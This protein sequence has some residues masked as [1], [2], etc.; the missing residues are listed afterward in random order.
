MSSVIERLDRIEDEF[1]ARNEAFNMDPTIEFARLWVKQHRLNS[2][3]RNSRMK[4]AVATNCPDWDIRIKIIGAVSEEVVADHEY[5]GGQAHF[6]MLE[7]LGTYLGMSREE[8]RNEKPLPTTQIAWL[9]WETLT[10]NRHW[11][12]GLLANTVGERANVPGYG[13]G[14]FRELGHSGVRRIT[15]AKNF[16]LKDDQLK[17]FKVHT[18]A[19]VAHSNLGWQNLAKYAEEMKMGDIIVEAARVNLQVWGLYWDGIV[20]AS[21]QLAGA[22]S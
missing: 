13:L 10:K 22:R 21:R 16:G 7:D 6:D 11:L 17:F 15:W 14:L 18:E 3:E 9:A 4:L 5:G 2:R 20:S 19:D 1:C 12:E 8:I